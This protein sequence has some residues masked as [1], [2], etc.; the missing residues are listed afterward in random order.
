MDIEHSRIGMER[1]FTDYSERVT[2]QGGG[3]SQSPRNV[4]KQFNISGMFTDTNM[5]NFEGFYRAF[6][7][8]PFPA[9]IA[10]GFESDRDENTRMAGF[11]FIR[12]PP[13]ISYAT[14]EGSYSSVSF[15]VT[16]II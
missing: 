13:Q 6:R 2:L 7:S 1:S 10:E 3:Y 4:V 14:S 5:K 12:N 11:F 8:Q 9:I 15:N 16:E